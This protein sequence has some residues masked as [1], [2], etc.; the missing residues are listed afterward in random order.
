MCRWMVNKL[1]DKIGPSRHIYAAILSL[2]P[3]LPATAYP[4]KYISLKKKK[5]KKDNMTIH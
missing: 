3:R 2:P 4:K 5:N 1:I